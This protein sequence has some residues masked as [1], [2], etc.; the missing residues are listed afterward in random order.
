M[1]WIVELEKHVVSRRTVSLLKSEFPDENDAIAYAEV[2][3]SEGFLSEDVDGE[4][5]WA[6]ICEASS[7]T[8][9]HADIIHKEEED[10]ECPE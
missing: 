3:G 1:Y 6:I 4:E 10:Y 7:F 9:D 2:C 8:P 5:C